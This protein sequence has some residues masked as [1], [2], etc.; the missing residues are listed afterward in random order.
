M[1][2]SEESDNNI[3]TKTRH[4]RGVEEFESVSTCFNTTISPIVV[5]MRNSFCWVN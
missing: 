2:L 4:I 5:E 1:H 3:E